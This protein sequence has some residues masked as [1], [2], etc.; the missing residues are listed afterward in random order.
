MQGGRPEFQPKYPEGFP[1]RMLVYNWFGR[2]RD[3]HPRMVDELYL[4]EMEWL[5]IV[6]EAVQAAIEQ[7]RD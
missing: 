2:M 1:Q 4:D 6:E 3:W 5:P 7:N